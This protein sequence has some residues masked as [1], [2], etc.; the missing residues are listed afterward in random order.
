MAEARE[1]RLAVEHHGGIR[2]EDKIRQATLRL[3]R[4]DRRAVA[5]ECAEQSLP[6]ARGSRVQR[7]A[8]LVPRGRI[9]PRIDAV[10]G[11]EVLRPAHQETR[12]QIELLWSGHPL[13]KTFSCWHS[14]R[15]DTPR[16][17]K[18]RDLARGRNL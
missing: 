13:P 10:G 11:G 3:D 4:L 6:L 8:A 5:T 18:H 17:A 2:G 14:A 9:H 16:D 12:P 1:Q 7:V 15:L